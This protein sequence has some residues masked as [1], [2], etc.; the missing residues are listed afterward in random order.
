MRINTTSG[1]PSMAWQLIESPDFVRRDLSSLE[2]MSYGGAA[3]APELTLKVL[4][5]SP[6][7][8]RAS[9]PRQAYGATETSSVST[10]ICAEDYQVRPGS[11]G[12]A[13]PVC[14]I[15]IVREDGSDA[16]VG[17]SG[18][19]WIA[20]P[21]VV[22]GYWNDPSATQASFEDGWYRTGDVG[23]VDAERF[24]YVLDRIKDVVIRGGENIYCAEI[25]AALYTHEAMLEA[26]VFGL[27]HRFS[28][29]RWQRS[30]FEGRRFCI[31]GG[32]AAA[33]GTATRCPQNSKV[34]RYP[35]G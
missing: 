19:I 8:C 14:D 32:F 33:Y 4:F 34:H 2:G 18:E 7:R 3:A 10:A 31:C 28:A 20:G 16:A 26:A 21:N 17:E 9:C 6:A 27:P 22:K 1:V 30:F 29:K 15:R 24:V 23:C 13:V 12:P 35:I 5:F 25:E 11:V